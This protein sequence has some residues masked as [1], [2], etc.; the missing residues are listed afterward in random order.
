MLNRDKILEEIV[1]VAKLSAKSPFDLSMMEGLD[2]KDDEDLQDLAIL[3]KNNLNKLQRAIDM[4]NGS[5]ANSILQAVKNG[6]ADLIALNR[7]L[8]NKT[9]DP[10]LKARFVVTF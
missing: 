6:L 2:L 10:V 7:A 5:E 8:A 1:T 9:E 4:G 3:V